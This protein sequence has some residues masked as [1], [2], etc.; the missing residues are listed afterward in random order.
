MNTTVFTRVFP[1]LPSDAIQTLQYDANFNE[2]AE[3]DH[4]G[5][6]ACVRGHLVLYPTRYL[7]AGG[8]DISV[9]DWSP[10]F[11]KELTH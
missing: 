10:G 2:A 4:A 1:N 9:L 7:E 3:G 6:M 5:L 11:L 8:F